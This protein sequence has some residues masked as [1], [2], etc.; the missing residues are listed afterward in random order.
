VKL[1]YFEEY[2]NRAEATKREMKIKKMKREDKI[3]LIKAK[4]DR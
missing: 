2:Q 4:N 1:L 3:Y